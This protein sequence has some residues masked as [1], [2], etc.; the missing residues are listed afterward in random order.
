MLWQIQKCNAAL[1]FYHGDII[2]V[3]E[4]LLQFPEKDMK[5]MINREIEEFKAEKNI[6]KTDNYG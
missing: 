3:A 2:G 6:Q 5:E 1:H 4:Y